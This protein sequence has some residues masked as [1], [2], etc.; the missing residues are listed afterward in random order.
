[1]ELGGG[2]RLKWPDDYFRIYLKYRLSLEKDFRSYDENLPDFSFV[3]NG[4]LSKLSLSLIRNDTDIPTF[5]NRGSILSLNT[6]VAGLGGD[7]AFVK[8]VVSYD[9]YFPLVWKF[10]FGMKSKFGV[11]GGLTEKK[12]IAR[13]DLFAAGGVYYEGQI[14]GY[15]EG[16][17]GRYN[18]EGL[19]LATFSGELR[20]PILEQQLY[21]A[22]F[23]D[24]GNVWNNLADIDLTD[25]F[26]GV[27]VGFR[28]M[29]PM[30]GLIGFDFAWGLKNENDPH[31]GGKKNGF[32]PHFLMN[33]GF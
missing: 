31:F 14:R 27:G 26:P 22:G 9:W 6:E 19:T 20:V 3:D 33:K 28:L 29:L 30:V 32:V 21:L 2:R 5:P 1:M 24:M 4:I 7:F 18:Q 16:A 11:I 13:S 15:S 12:T 17:F 8:N 23:F 25:M 10:V